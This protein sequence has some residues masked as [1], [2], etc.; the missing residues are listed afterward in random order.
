MKKIELKTISKAS[1]VFEEIL[2]DHSK[3]YE[4]FLEG[5]QKIIS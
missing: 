5:Y 4:R 3:Y 1:E 2:I